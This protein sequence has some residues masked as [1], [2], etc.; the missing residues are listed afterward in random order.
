MC[1]FPSSASAIAVITTCHYNCRYLSALPTAT[2]TG[3]PGP[4]GE[5][6]AEPGAG[7]YMYSCGGTTG[8]ARVA[9]IDMTNSSHQCP[10]DMEEVTLSGKRVCGRCSSATDRSCVSATFSASGLQ[11]SQVCG[12]IRGYQYG[13]TYAFQYGLSSK[14]IESW[15]VDGVSVTHGPPGS[16]KHVWTFATGYRESYYGGAACPCAPNADLSRIRVPSF[17]GQD[18]FCESGVSGRSTFIRF[19][20]EDPL[21]DGDG[22]TLAGNTCCQFNNPPYFTKQ[23]NTTTGDDLEVRAC[24]LFTRDSGVGDTLIELIELY[25]KL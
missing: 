25:I 16:R 18:Y 13:W 22:C 9:Y 21:W 3:E 23:L 12:R 5:K 6:G 11:Y 2:P 19:Y 24:G 20:P 14:S 7:T 10:G 15:Y 17:V 1:S 4:N 8:W